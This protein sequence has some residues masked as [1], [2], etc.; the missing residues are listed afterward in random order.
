GNAEALSLE[1]RI[2]TLDAGT[3]AD[4]VVLDAAATPAMALKM[5]VVR[6][7]T[8]E[9]FLLQTLGDDRAVRETYVA[10]K[11]MKATL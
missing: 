1:D 9:L 7:L 4:F 2:G 11:P 6:S 8:D 10:G 3:D 5:E